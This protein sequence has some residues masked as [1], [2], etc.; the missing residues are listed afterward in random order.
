MKSTKFAKIFG[1]GPV[2][3]VIS[4][5]LLMVAVWANRRFDL[6]QIS[7][8][9]SVLNVIFYISIFFTVVA[10]IWSF[11]SLPATDRGNNLCTKGAFKYVSHPLYAAFLTIFD[12][13]LAFY[14][15]GYIFIL[16][17]AL[18][19]PIWHYLIKYEEQLM[20]N[21]FGKKYLDYRK[22]TGRFFPRLIIKK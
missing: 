19:H 16:W 4:V 20:I 18:L 8:N 22:Q 3:L 5:F 9:Q 10:I 11:K 21:I 14:L 13:G 2:G 7:D 1:S 12:F 6:P 17:A 15:N